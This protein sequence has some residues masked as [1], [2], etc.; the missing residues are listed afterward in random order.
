MNLLDIILD[1]SSGAN[2]GLFRLADALVGNPGAGLANTF[3]ANIPQDP[4]RRT[5]G[6]WGLGNAPQGG[7]TAYSLAEGAGNMAGQMIP[8]VGD[9]GGFAQD[10]EELQQNPTLAGALLASAG[11]LPLVPSG[12]HHLRNMAP[13][14]SADTTRNVNLYAEMVRRGDV[15]VPFERDYPVDSRPAHTPDGRLLV[16]MYEDPIHPEAM[17]I[18]RQEIDG[19]NVPMDSMKAVEAY[20][21]FVDYSFG[22]K[23]MDEL[24]ARGQLHLR[25]GDPRLI[26][27]ASDMPVSQKE[28]TFAHELGHATHYLN[29]SHLAGMSRFGDNP[30]N[31]PFNAQD[32][33]EATGSLNRQIYSFNHGEDL[34][35]LYDFTQNNNYGLSIMTP[36]RRGYAPEAAQDE[37]IAEAYRMYMQTPGLMKE[38][39]P[40]L[41][42]TLSAAVKRTPHLAKRIHFN[43]LV[44]GAI[45]TGALANVLLPE[46]ENRGEAF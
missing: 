10:I 17:I 34:D 19:P 4:I 14:K 24:G 23:T 26:E 41:A 45:G 12:L 37:K 5:M 35:R 2:S 21:P 20:Y 3:G 33:A 9:V 18:G 39:F 46:D 7:S 42:E 13:K 28:A 22:Q 44:P 43:Q 25:D 40:E 8:G 38:M 15:D 32:L 30:G 11:L 27:V 31:V 6:E 29:Q 1:T 16:D 36:E